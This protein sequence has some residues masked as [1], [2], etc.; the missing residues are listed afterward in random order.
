LHLS[1][2]ENSKLG[3]CKGKEDISKST[4]ISIPKKINKNKIVHKAASTNNS[5][6]NGS[7]EINFSNKT[8]RPH[9]I[10]HKVV[11]NLK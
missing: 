8:T 2:I 5:K 11:E 6:L 4:A 9:N 10:K 7:V 1:Y 3:N